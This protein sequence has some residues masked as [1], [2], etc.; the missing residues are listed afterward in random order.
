L[1]NSVKQNFENIT[2]SEKVNLDNEE[3][4]L[5]ILL[6]RSIDTLVNL[7]DQKLEVDFQE[8]PKSNWEKDGD[9]SNYVINVKKMLNN[10]L[11]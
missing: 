9:M 2:L 7:F 6:N 10:N 11:Y 1:V 8:I 4:N 5:N 3:E